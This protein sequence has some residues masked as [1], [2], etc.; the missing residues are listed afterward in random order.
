MAAEVSFTLNEQDY[1]DAARAQFRRRAISP[2]QWLWALAIL[3][4]M[5]ASVGYLGPCDLGSPIYLG[6][7]FA[8]LVLLICP[9]FAGAGYLL[10]GR[11]ARRMFRQQNIHPE[12]RMAWSDEGLQIQNELGSSNTKWRD[13]Y[14]WRE[15]RGNF[16]LYFNEAIYYLIPARAI[17]AEQA[18][19]LEDTLVRS[20]LAK[21]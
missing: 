4:G 8:G 11:S 15:D 14:G 17:S 1:V 19:D 6:S 7:A 10:A 3:A 16:T 13:F 12:S 2:R 9:P 21:R 18:A 5:S 20:D